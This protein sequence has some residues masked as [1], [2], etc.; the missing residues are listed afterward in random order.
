MLA[1]PVSPPHFG[2]DRLLPAQLCGARHYRPAVQELRPLVPTDRPG[3]RGVLRAPGG[4]RSADL[5]GSRGLPAVDQEAVRRSGVQGLP[6]GV[7]E[8]LCLDQ[9]RPYHRRAVLRLERTGQRDEKEMRPGGHH[10]GRVQGLAGEA[11]RTNRQ[12]MNNGTRLGARPVYS[13][14]RRCRF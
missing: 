8:A 7:Q 12:K 9:G 3:Q 2:H 14:Y 1:G 4:L 11:V 5:P 6:Q 13:L 10:P